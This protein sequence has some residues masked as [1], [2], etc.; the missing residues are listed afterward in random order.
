[1]ENFVNGIVKAEKAKATTVEIT[2]GSPPPMA[3]KKSK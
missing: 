1:M 2:E 3:P